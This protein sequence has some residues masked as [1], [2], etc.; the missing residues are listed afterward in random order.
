MEVKST[1]EAPQTQSSGDIE[2]QVYQA[3][4]RKA[5]KTYLGHPDRAHNTLNLSQTEGFLFAVACC[6]QDVQTS[7]WLQVVLGEEF[8]DEDLAQ[9]GLDQQLE[10]LYVSIRELVAEGAYRLPED[11]EFSWDAEERRSFEQWCEGALL[12]DEWLESQWMDALSQAYHRDPVSYEK[13]SHDLDD[14]IGLFKIMVD[15]DAA[16]EVLEKDSAAEVDDFRQQ[17]RDSYEVF[18]EYLTAYMKAGNGLA[19]YYHSDPQVRQEPKIGRND[20]CP[21]GSGKKY[22]K[23]CLN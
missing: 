13:L 12:A 4:D 1:T 11:Y 14:V 8:I 6:P 16:L 19:V 18:N 2:G 20:A 17:L 21:C 22:K 7:D 5:L 10:D 3:V 9:Q 15:V 23:C